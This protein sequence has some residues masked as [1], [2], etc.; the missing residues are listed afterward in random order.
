[1][2]YIKTFENKTVNKDIVYLAK[3]QSSYSGSKSREYVEEVIE[4]Y[5]MTDEQIHNLRLAIEYEYLDFNDFRN[6]LALIINSNKTDT[7][8]IWT[9]FDSEKKLKKAYQEN[10]KTKII[11]IEEPYPICYLTW[12]KYKWDSTQYDLESFDF[13][14]IIGEI[15][16]E[17]PFGKKY[18]I[19]KGRYR[20]D[21][22]T[23]LWEKYKD[24]KRESEFI[25][26]VDE[27]NIYILTEDDIKNCKV[28]N[29]A[30]NYNL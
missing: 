6:I 8:R 28:I 13:N 27:K 16:K 1:M 19:G 21:D 2:K 18:L 30:K 17:Y 10:F 25:K 23:T 7:D 9:Y 20:G 22:D 24:T 11:N 3:K 4:Y 5:K 29:T 15:P 26:V 12:N 14:D